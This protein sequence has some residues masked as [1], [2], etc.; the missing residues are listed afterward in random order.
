MTTWDVRDRRGALVTDLY[1]LAEVMHTTPVDAAKALLAN[2]VMTAAAPRSLLS[3][4][5]ASAKPGD[6]TPPPISNGSFVSFSGGKGRVDLIVKKGKVPGVEGDVE[7][8]DASP[9]ARVVVWKDGKATREKRAFNT[10]RLKRIAPLD[11]PE[12]KADPASR[13]VAL[14]SAHE[15]R[16]SALGLSSVQRVTGEAVKS[17]YD[18]GIEAY[19]GAD[20]TSLTR[21]EWALARAEHFVKVAA[22]SVDVKSAGN[23]VDLLHPDHP[24]RSK[25][26]VYLNPADL[27]ATVKA[28]LAAA[29]D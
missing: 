13:L 28:L 5:K 8:T 17:V 20:R 9:A 26:K 16:C 2:P 4:V 25:A 29:Q 18:R 23:D 1:S 7:A 10:H 24:L 11:G 27:D 6:G 14:V 22:G 3:E 19:P 12:K 15:T 21:Q